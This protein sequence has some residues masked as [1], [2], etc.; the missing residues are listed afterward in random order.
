MRRDGEQVLLIRGRKMSINGGSG[1]EGPPF[2]QLGGG[3]LGG[4]SLMKPMRWGQRR[5]K[6]A[7]VLVVVAAGLGAGAGLVRHWQWG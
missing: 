5:G 4:Q 3:P 2:Q 6:S 1:E 7:A